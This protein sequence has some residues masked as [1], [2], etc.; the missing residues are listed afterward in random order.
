MGIIKMLF[1]VFL[2]LT[3]IIGG[4]ATTSWCSD[5]PRQLCRMGCMPPQCSSNQCAYRDGTC[6]SYTCKSNVPE[7]SC[8]LGYRNGAKSSDNELCM[9]PSERGRRPCY[10]RP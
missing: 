4:F 8:A 5:S 6:C 9:G 10:P 1:K 7:C 3:N 2:F